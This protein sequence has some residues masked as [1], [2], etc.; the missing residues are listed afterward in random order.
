D[1][2]LAEKAKAKYDPKR[3]QEAKEYIED[4]SGEKFSSSSF[5]ESLKD[6]VLLCKMMNRIMPNPPIKITTS[7][8]PFKQMENIAAFLDRVEK[9]GVPAYDRFL[10][11]DL[12]EAKNMDQVIN[13][14]FSLSRYAAAAGFDGPVL[15]PK[16]ASRN[17]RTFSEEQLAQSKNIVPKLASFTSKV[18]S[19][20][21]TGGRREIG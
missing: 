6:G 5:H 2:Q 3:E 19:T 8:M 12:Y 20:P 16:L 17:E 18:G 13:C 4:I 15:G 1:P 14:I 9:L 7:K 11:V 10:T 21:L